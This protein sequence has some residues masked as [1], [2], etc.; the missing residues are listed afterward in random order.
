MELSI[1]PTTERR[2]LLRLRLQ[3]AAECDDGIL[4]RKVVL[5]VPAGASLDRK[6]GNGHA[7]Q[8]K[9]L[10]GLSFVSDLMHYIYRYFQLPLKPLAI[11]VQGFGL[12]PAQR[13]EDVLRDG[14]LIWVRPA[15]RRPSKQKALPQDHPVEHIPALEDPERKLTKSQASAD[16]PEATGTF[17]AEQW[18][19]MARAPLPGEVIRYR[20]QDGENLTD[21]KVAVCIGAGIAAG[22]SQVT[23]QSGEDV[24]TTAVNALH[25]LYL[26]KVGVEE[27]V[28]TPAALPSRTNFPNKLK[29]EQLRCAI[30]RQFEFY[31]GD[32]NYPKD[33]FLRSQADDEGW[34][35]LRL[36][37]KFNRV[38][39]LTFDLDLIRSCLAPCFRETD[40]WGCSILIVEHDFS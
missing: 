13:L 27:T 2:S 28:P 8:R 11:S 35:P 26:A 38:R 20:L 34:T 23:L 36:V 17:D 25:D 39:E 24:F 37:S 10:A 30:R 6:R 33:N 7:S 18:R 1:C 29:A 12:L 22:L 21:P 19:Q 3:L 40:E 14:D 31:F 5:A 32:V 15:Q 9:P 16:L 4:C